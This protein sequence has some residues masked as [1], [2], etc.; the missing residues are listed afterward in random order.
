[1]RQHVHTR[2]HIHRWT[3]KEKAQKEEAGGKE[4]EKGKR[5]KEEGAELKGAKERG[6]WGTGVG[7]CH[8]HIPRFTVASQ[9]VCFF[10]LLNW[11][12]GIVTVPGFARE[13]AE[14]DAP[15]IENQWPISWRTS[16]PYPPSNNLGCPDPILLLDYVSGYESPLLLVGS[17]KL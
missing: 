14:G 1:M 5:G 4:K 9:G 17:F 6:Y 15:T 8:G 12:W 13:R 2:E 11:Y 10:V 16:S 3:K 7:P